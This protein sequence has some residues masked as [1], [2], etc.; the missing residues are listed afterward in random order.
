MLQEIFYNE[1][2]A[3][4]AQIEPYR[5]S[6]DGNSSDDQRCVVHSVTLDGVLQLV[7]LSLTKG[8]FFEIPTMIPTRVRKFWISNSGLNWREAE[9]VIGYSKANFTGARKT[10]AS[11]VALDN[12]SGEIR[13]KIEGFEIT[14]IVGPSF[15]F[16]AKISERRLCYSFDWRSD[17]DLLSNS[18][19]LAYCSVE[20]PFIVQPV[21]FCQNLE[22]LF[23][24]H[25]KN[26]RKIQSNQIF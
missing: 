1:E 26:Y 24:L 2:G 14:A 18:Q 12:F 6:F 8:G 5:D 22:F 17:M 19:M 21:E 15:F 3:A 16:S 25:V 7:F 9:R 20:C 11:I 4:I 10:D 13:I 23:H